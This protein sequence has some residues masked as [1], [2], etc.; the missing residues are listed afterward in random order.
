MRGEA[1]VPFRR[2]FSQVNAVERTDPC[3]QRGHPC[4]P[5]SHKDIK[6]SQ[7]Y[8]RCTAFSLSFGVSDSS[9]C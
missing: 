6:P 3:E 4:A 1:E 7:I 2:H 9:C 8:A 5:I